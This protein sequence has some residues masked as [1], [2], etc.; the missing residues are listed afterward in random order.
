MESGKMVQIGPICKADNRDKD[1]ENKCTD[2]RGGV[3]VGWAGDGYGH[4]HITMYKA[5]D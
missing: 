2:S 4:I 3:G 5:D 1:V